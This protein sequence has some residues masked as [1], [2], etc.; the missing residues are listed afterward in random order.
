MSEAA[1]RGKNGQMSLLHNDV[2]RMYDIV[3][4]QTTIL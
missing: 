1:Q 4:R 3:D 2:L